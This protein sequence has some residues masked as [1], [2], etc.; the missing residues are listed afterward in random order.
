[1]LKLLGLSKVKD[2]K[3]PLVSHYGGIEQSW[4][5]VFSEQGYQREKKTLE[6]KLIIKDQGL[7]NIFGI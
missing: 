5:L 7:K 3:L 1:M 6:K 2:T 4:L